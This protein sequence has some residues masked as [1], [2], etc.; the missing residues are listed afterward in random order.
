MTDIIGEVFLNR[1]RVDAF[2]ASGGMG[3]VYRA[4]D[5][6]RNVALA[7]KVLH[8][9]RMDDPGAFK[10]FQREARALE[11]LRHPNIV[12]FYGFYPTEDF[13]FFLEHY[14]DGPSLHGILRKQ[15]GGLPIPEALGYMQALCS[16]LGYA[17]AK[18]V[19]HCDIK[20]GNVMVDRGGQIYLTD[21]GIAR[22]AESATTT[23]AGAGTPA[24]M[25]PEQ[26]RAEPVTPATDVYSLGVLL[27]EMLT[28]QR[29]FHGDEAETLGKGA[30]TGERI[31]YAHLHLPPPDPRSLN[32]TLQPALTR[33]ITRCMA[34]APQDRY[35]STA[36]LLV[37][38]QGLGV[39]ANERAQFIPMR[40]TAVSS[41]P[42]TEREKQGQYVPPKGATKAPE[43]QSTSKWVWAGGAAVLGVGLCLALIIGAMVFSPNAISPQA[44]QVLPTVM[45][46]VVETPSDNIPAATDTALAVVEILNTA[47]PPSPTIPA[48]ETATPAPSLSGKMMYLLRKNQGAPGVY[49]QDMADSEGRAQQILAQSSDGQYYAPLLSPDGLRMVFYKSGEGSWVVDNLVN[50][51]FRKL[52]SCT[53][54][55]WSPDGSRLICSDSYLQIIDSYSGSMLEKLTVRGNLPVWSPTANEI[56]Y[57]QKNGDDT[58]VWR[59]NLDNGEHILLAGN[60]NQNYAPAW[61]PDGQWIAYQSNLES[62]DSQVWVMERN[63]QNARQVTDMG[64]WSRA[65]AWSPDG[66]TLAFVSDAEGS[67]GADYGEIFL[68]S[69]ISSEIR[70]FTSTDGSVYD[71]RISWNK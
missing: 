11:K 45:E 36:A 32:P 6:E 47:P 61:S 46:L 33:I 31:R 8:A 53:A 12:P 16:A 13:S 37:D 55:S 42:N 63:G 48:T 59:Y 29:P 28:G 34:K 62:A 20:P 58:S 49:V 66:S 39:Q 24:Y 9:E 19:V 57:T 54:P 17:H 23:I 38:L 40:P 70:Q 4:W 71:W 41:A 7:M 52:N 22:H 21:F 51:N 5:L 50:G 65:P 2:V 18:G 43:T 30:T 26:I 44:E 27:F 15:A 69:L 64:N 25:A 14:I 68:V 10:Y 56:A 35:P 67:A 3:A 60:G 1:F